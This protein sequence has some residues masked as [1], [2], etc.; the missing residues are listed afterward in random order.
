MMPKISHT[1]PCMEKLQISQVNNVNDTRNY[2][3]AGVGSSVS[4]IL[5]RTISYPRQSDSKIPFVSMVLMHF[6]KNMDDTAK[7]SA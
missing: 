2:S 7:F 4:V 1:D 5:V 6:T 3:D